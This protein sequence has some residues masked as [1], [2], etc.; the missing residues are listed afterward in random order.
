MT[1]FRQPIC[2]YAAGDI[3]GSYQ[4]RTRPTMARVCIQNALFSFGRLGKSG[5]ANWSCVDDVPDPEVH[6]GLTVDGQAAG[7]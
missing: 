5:S 3:A 7:R 1:F 2:I 4:F 6:V